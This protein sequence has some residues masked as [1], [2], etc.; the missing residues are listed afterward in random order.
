MARMVASLVVMNRLAAI[1]FIGFERSDGYTRNGVYLFDTI[2]L[3][4]PEAN[5]QQVIG[6]GQVDIDR[7]S[8][9]P[10]VASVEITYRYVRRGYRPIGAEKH[11]GRAYVRVALRLHSRR[12]Q[13]GCPYHKYTIPTI[14]L[15]HPCVLIRAAEVAASLS[16]SISSLM[17]RS[18]SIYVSEPGR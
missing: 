9:D 12:S 8:L 15:L 4:A 16:L 10:E 2:N 18:F 7:I 6:I 3:V 14:L 1:D 11:C 5:P 17:A 13:P